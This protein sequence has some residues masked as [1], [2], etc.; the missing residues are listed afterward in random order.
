[1]RNS[2]KQIIEVVLA[3][4]YD[5]INAL[6]KILKYIKGLRKITARSRYLNKIQSLNYL[7]IFR[8]NYLQEDT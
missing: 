1:M 5:G 3:S 8:L 6:G 7:L 4:K 2:Q